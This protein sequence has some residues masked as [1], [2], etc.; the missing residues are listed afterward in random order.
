MD[1]ERRTISFED[2]KALL[3]EQFAVLL[4]RAGENDVSIDQLT[5]LN[6]SI[7][8]T[9][10]TLFALDEKIK[11]RKE[12]LNIEFVSYNGDYPNLCS[13]VLQ[14]KVEGRV[15]KFGCW[16]DCDYPSFW[17]SGGGFDDD[18]NAYYGDWII[19]EKEL[20]DFLKPYVDVISKL[21]NE[22]VPKGCCGG[23]E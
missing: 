3:E 6:Q 17:R 21:L 12:K 8:L 7:C 9:T 10:L 18:Y 23:C 20:P 5:Q 14:L 11:A 15:L 19:S 1:P 16:G 2:A 13:G 4:E 22:N